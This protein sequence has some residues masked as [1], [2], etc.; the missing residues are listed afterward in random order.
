[1]TGSIKPSRSVDE[2]DEIME[3]KF[4]YR[5]GRSWRNRRKHALGPDGEK[6]EQANVHYLRYERFWILLCTKGKHRFFE[7]HVKRDRNGD[8]V[9]KH[10]RDAER[11]PIF[12]AGYSIRIA[13][14]GY[15]PRWKWRDAKTPELDTKKRVRVRIAEETFRD[16]K[17]ELVARAGSGRY[18][19]AVLEAAVWNLPFLPYAPVRENLCEIVRHMNRARKERGFKDLL[20]ASRC[21][22]RRIPPVKAFA[23]NESV[24]FQEIYGDAAP[25]IARNSPGETISIAE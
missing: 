22:R 16:I 3:Q 19:A 13:E 1:M 4:R 12:F 10:F 25:T 8:I 21:I 11:D 7:E 14:G 17:A 5:M 15:L 24:R 2:F 9:A 23:P 18:A 6:L 20:V